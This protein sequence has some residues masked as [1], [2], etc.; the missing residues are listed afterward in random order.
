MRPTAFEGGHAGATAG[1]V[2]PVGFFGTAGRRL[3][4]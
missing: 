2:A 3:N 4:A 1:A